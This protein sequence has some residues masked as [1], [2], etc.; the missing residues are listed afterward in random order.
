M[1][2]DNNM[3]KFLEEKWKKNDILMK[4]ALEKMHLKFS[5]N[6]KTWEVDI[7][8]S[9]ARYSD[10]YGFASYDENYNFVDEGPNTPESLGK[11]KYF[12]E[13]VTCNIISNIFFGINN[14]EE[15]QIKLDL[16]A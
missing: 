11:I 6:T 5:R 12:V 10:Y 8:F 2:E 1:L 13:S 7:R 3:T 15:L 14:Y 4:A 16:M 9:G